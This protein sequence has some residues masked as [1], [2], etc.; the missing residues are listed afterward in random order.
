MCRVLALTLFFV[1]VF[2]FADCDAQMSE[3][4]QTLHPTLTFDVEHAFCAASSNSPNHFVCIN[5]LTRPFSRDCMR[6]MPK[7]PAL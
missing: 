5:S 3:W 2:A 4:A 1:P 7:R 6:P